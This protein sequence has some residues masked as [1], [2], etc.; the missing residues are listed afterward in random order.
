MVKRF[1]HLWKSIPILYLVSLLAIGCG[2]PAINFEATRQPA[3]AT[4]SGLPTQTSVATL[5]PTDVEVHPTPTESLLSASATPEPT[6]RETAGP[7]LLPT[8]TE[9]PPRIE[10]FTVSPSPA[11]PTSLVTLVWKVPGADS[12]TI[13][14]LDK[15]TETVSR[16]GLSPAGSMEVDPSA[17]KFSDGDRLRFSIYAFDAAGDILLG[18]DGELVGETVEIPIYTEL[19]IAS[20]SAEPDPIERSGEVTLSWSAPKAVS[21]GITRLSE[22]GGIFLVT[23]ALDLPAQGSIT[24]QVP[25]NYVTQVIY[26]LGARDANGVLRKAYVTVGIRCPYADYLAPQCPL[27]RETIW[28]AY[29]PFEHGHM[30][31]RSDRREIWALYDGGYYEPYDDTYQ[32]GQPSDIE[33]VPPHGLFAPVRGFGKVWATLPWVRARLGWATG[34][35]SGYDMLIETLRV[36]YGRYPGTVHYFRLP[37]DTVVHL[38]VSWSQWEVLP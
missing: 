11:D 31:W 13:Q 20:F 14:W 22:E 28:A 10:V 17:I 32:E 35:E 29:E 9:Q 23:E 4:A 34:P 26:Y 36:G 3:T 37:D 2:A 21:L 38:T 6:R 30:V 1:P 15:R 7:T 8:A 24:L 33:E 18:E 19:E 16:S 12:V 25:D 5:L 27:T